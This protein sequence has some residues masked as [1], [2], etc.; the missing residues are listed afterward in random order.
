MTDSRPVVCHIVEDLKYGGV[1]ELIRL[2]VTQTSQDKFRVIVCAIEEGGMTAETLIA[3]GVPVTVLGH[4]TYH[5]WKAIKD[6]V[7][8]LKNNKVSIIHSHMY[9]ANMAA[10]WANVFAQCPVM[11]TTAYS[12]Y[13][14]RKWH[15]RFMEWFWSFSTDRII[16]AAEVIR[17]YT[18]RQS[19]INPN[20]FAVIYDAAKDQRAVLEQQKLTRLQ[21]REDLNIDPNVFVISCVARLDPVKGHVYLV[22]ALALLVEKYPDVLLLLAG[23]GPEEDNLKK[24]VKSLGLQDHVRFLGVCK[25][26]WRVLGAADVFT[27]TSSIREGCPLS[28]L[29]AMSMGL[30][31]VGTRMGGIPEEVE[32]GITGLLVEPRTAEPLSLAFC[33]LYSDKALRESM[34]KAARIRY[35]SYFAPQVMMDKIEKLYLE[36]LE[37]KTHK[38]NAEA[39]KVRHD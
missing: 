9:F 36:I 32:E 15:Q 38:K 24:Q 8:F 33:E 14:E 2:I 18:S 4:K 12:T 10:R 16:A 25:E 31:V 39:V 37:M 6:L 23:D 13:H 11:I 26:V 17:S 5:S 19:W 3:S 21:L 7:S 22:Q 34:A 1:E 30:P 35:D 20:K 29:E 28:V 27:L